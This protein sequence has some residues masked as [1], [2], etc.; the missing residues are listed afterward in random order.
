MSAE[1]LP[2]ALDVLADLAGFYQCAEQFALARAAARCLLDH[3][4]SRP[5]LREQVEEIL[6]NLP[7]PDGEEL[8]SASRR[9][10]DLFDEGWTAG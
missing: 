9:M 4:D 1:V 2:T 6:A 5:I 3:P 10:E 8:L 7:R